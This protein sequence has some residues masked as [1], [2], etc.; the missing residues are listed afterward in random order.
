LVGF[1]NW[2]QNHLDLSDEN[3]FVKLSL[4]KTIKDVQQ[5]S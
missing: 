3:F 5:V 1:V 2:I 4:I